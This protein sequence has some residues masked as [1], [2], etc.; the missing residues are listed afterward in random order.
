M[1]NDNL[2]NKGYGTQ[3]EKQAIEY[4]FQELGLHT[5]YADVIHKNKRSQ[6]VLTKVGFRE[7]H[8][9]DAF[10]YYRC[11]RCDWVAAGQISNETL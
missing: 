3:A 5:V 9:D 2:K 11:D 4:A 8:R 1:Q 7:T 10:I 6:H